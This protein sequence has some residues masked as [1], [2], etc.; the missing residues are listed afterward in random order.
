MS[1]NDRKHFSFV[2]VSVPDESLVIFAPFSAA[3]RSNAQTLPDI[4]DPDHS[5]DMSSLRTWEI[6]LFDD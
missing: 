3:F 5:F 6:R 2:R 1:N 4:F